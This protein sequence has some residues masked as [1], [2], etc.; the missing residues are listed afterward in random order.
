MWGSISMTINC[1]T[2]APNQQTAVSVNKSDFA[3]KRIHSSNMMSSNWSFVPRKFYLYY[4]IHT[5]LDNIMDWVSSC[6]VILSNRLCVANCVQ[7]NPDFS[8]VEGKR[9]LVQRIREFE[10]SG[11]KLQWGKSKGN[12]FWF[13]VWGFWEIESSRNRDSTV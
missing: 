5:I 1:A 4:E 13:E 10:I 8:N 3:K 12:D 11:I 7:W 9:K 2:V 6:F